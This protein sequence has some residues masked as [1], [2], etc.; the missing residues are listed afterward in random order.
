MDKL[1]RFRKLVPHIVAIVIFIGLSYSYFSPLLE[2][3]DIQQ[4]DITHFK[5]MSKEVRDYRA[6]TGEEA[7]WTNRLFG[8]MPA[9]FAGTKFKN[10][11]TTSLEKLLTFPA[12]PANFLFLYLIGFY[13]ALLLFRVNPWLS[14]VGAIAFAFSSYFFIIIAAGHNTKALAIGYM[15][16]I[17][18][19]I[20]HTYRYKRW[21]GLIL[22]GIFLSLQIE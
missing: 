10:N 14:I 16:P 9:Y 4:S 6:D 8:G 22:T 3:K 13:I 20:I 17:V 2:G 19:S 15:A 5:G 12:K 21:T 7:L 11:H 1:I 18:A